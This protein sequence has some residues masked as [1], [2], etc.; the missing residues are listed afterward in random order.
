M[1]KQFIYDETVFGGLLHPSSESD[2]APSTCVTLLTHYHPLRD[3]GAFLFSGDGH[4]GV[5]DI[6]GRVGAIGRT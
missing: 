2:D 5:G 1:C 4:F 3:S 6:H